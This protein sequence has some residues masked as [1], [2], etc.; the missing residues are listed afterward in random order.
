[1]LPCWV[2]TGI[3]SVVHAIFDAVVCARIP[4]TRHTA[5]LCRIGARRGPNKLIERLTHV[6]FANSLVNHHQHT[7]PNE[8]NR[9]GSAVSPSFIIVL[10]RHAID[11][12]GSPELKFVGKINKAYDT[13]H[14][15]ED[16]NHA[17]KR[18]KL[19][20]TFIHGL[21]HE[22]NLFRS[23]KHLPQKSEV[24]Q[25]RQLGATARV[26]DR[27]SIDCQ[28]DCQG[29]ESPYKALSSVE[30]VVSKRKKCIFSKKAHVARNF[31]IFKWYFEAF[32]IF[33]A[34]LEVSFLKL[35]S[36]KCGNACHGVVDDHDKLQNQLHRRQHTFKRY[37][38]LTRQVYLLHFLPRG[39]GIALQRIAPPKVRQQKDVDEKNIAKIEYV[40]DATNPFHKHGEAIALNPLLVLHVE[41]QVIDTTKIVSQSCDV[42]CAV[43]IP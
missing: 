12:I 36:H 38:G 1:M 29:R 7:L 43:H 13:K 10:G 34:R 26:C 22:T 9:N 27:D 40:T 16:E 33:W 19:M 30:V 31:L 21:D 6:I 5:I 3:F 39:I 41:V 25:E 20:T 15:A 23:W 32:S 42:I 28:G 37:L 14:V 18:E 24:K 8:V 17:Q 4:R 2:G 35:L 11:Y